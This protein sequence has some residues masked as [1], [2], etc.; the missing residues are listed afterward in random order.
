MP[1]SGIS[2]TYD[3]PLGSHLCLFYRST[4][5]FLDVTA[6][7]LKAGLN[8]NELCVWVLPRPV[9][10]PAAL[11]ELSKHGLD[12]GA[13]Q[14]TKQLH[15]ASANTW[16]AKG[17]FDVAHSLNQ[18]SALPAIASQLGFASVRGVAGP[19]PFLSGDAR[20]PFMRYER[21]ATSL[22]AQ[23]PLI[24]LCCYASAE[25]LQKDIFDIMDA[26]P[27]ALLRTHAGWVSI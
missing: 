24:G 10:M 16:F 17:S 7:F 22:I 11:I 9:T 5:E 13:L 14:A 21:Q 20:Q 19:G 27:R 3:I 26:H 6:S 12:G 18:L 4:K 15:I 25:C 1:T 2:G 23:I 8:H